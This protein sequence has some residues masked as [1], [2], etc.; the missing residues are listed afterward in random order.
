MDGFVNMCRMSCFPV[1]PVCVHETTSIDKKKKI[2]STRDSITL[3]HIY[4]LT[5]LGSGYCVLLKCFFLGGKLSQELLCDPGVE[6]TLKAR[7]RRE[8]RDVPIGN[9]LWVPFLSLWISKTVDDFVEIRDSTGFSG[10][11]TVISYLA[12]A[13]DA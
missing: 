5:Q 8:R 3:N 10:I 6:E 11:L 12:S 1:V 2:Y 13:V 4:E 7:R 9:D